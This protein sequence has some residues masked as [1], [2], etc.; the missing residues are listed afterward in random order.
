VGTAATQ[1][2]VQQY[3]ESLIRSTEA[4]RHNTQEAD[5]RA[6]AAEGISVSEYAGDEIVR[7]KRAELNAYVADEVARAVRDAITREHLTGLDRQTQ[8]LHYIL[9]AVNTEHT[10]NT[11]QFAAIKQRDDRSWSQAI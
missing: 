5:R 2:T 11:V 9:T 8:I 1:T 3:I 7:M 4:A 10:S 6:R